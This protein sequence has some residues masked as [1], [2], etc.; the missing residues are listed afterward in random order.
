MVLLACLS[1]LRLLKTP[2]KLEFYL[3]LVINVGNDSKT[4]ATIYINEFDSIL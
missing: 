2:H 4:L 3:Q 1:L